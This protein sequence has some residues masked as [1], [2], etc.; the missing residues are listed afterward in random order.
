MPAAVTPSN[1]NGWIIANLDQAKLNYTALPSLK[2]Q[3]I[4][5]E[6]MYAW[7]NFMMGSM[8]LEVLASGAVIRQPVTF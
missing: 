4:N 6:S 1:A 7:F 2:S 8:M 3:G 5:E